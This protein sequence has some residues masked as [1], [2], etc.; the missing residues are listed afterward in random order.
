MSLTPSTISF[1]DLLI[2][3]ND[4]LIGCFA[5]NSEMILE[6][7]YLPTANLNIIESEVIL[8]KMKDIL[9]KSLFR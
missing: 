6:V 5:F 9:L 3:K 8:E 2:Y 1:N 4:K 7:S